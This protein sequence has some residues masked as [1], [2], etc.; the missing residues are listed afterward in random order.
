MEPRAHRVVLGAIAGELDEWRREELRNGYVERVGAID[1]DAEAV[2]ALV[3]WIHERL[4]AGKP[5][6]AWVRALCE[7]AQTHTLAIELLAEKLEP[8]TTLQA[9]L[10]H[11]DTLDEVLA[12][13]AWRHRRVAKMTMAAQTEAA[14]TVRAV[15]GSNSRRS[16][17]DVRE[18]PAGMRSTMRNRWTPCV[19]KPPAAASTVC[20]GPISA[21]STLRDAYADSAHQSK[22]VLPARPVT[23]K[24]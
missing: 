8:P 18:A 6:D 10:R 19:V 7:T 21:E 12:Q 13:Q 15:T 20:V 5:I 3:G 23:P 11:A 1:L 22:I 14:R 4:E 24:P 2:P 16:G 17:Q 9:V